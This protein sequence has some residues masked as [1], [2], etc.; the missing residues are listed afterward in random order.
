[1][2][3]SVD[4]CSAPSRA[5]GYCTKH[6]LR[7]RRHGDPL[8]VKNNIP[9]RG[10]IWAFFEAAKSYQGDDC[11][12]WPFSRDGRGYG[13]LRLRGDG[14]FKKRPAHRAICEA[15]YGPPPDPTQLA[16]HRCG[17]GH[18]GCVSPK[19]LKWA[20]HKENMEDMVAHNRSTRGSKNPVAKLTADD[21]RKIRSLLGTMSQPAIA[22]M[23]GVSQ[24]NI[25]CI[26][27]EISWGHTR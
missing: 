12:T 18:L 5:S 6:Y 7:F 15:V 4:N 21:V 9:P 13:Y 14:A 17:N 23:F 1:M 25:S 10:E 3:C 16:T 26:K 8:R 27:R 2:I 19:H 22:R 11:L 24:P 20:T